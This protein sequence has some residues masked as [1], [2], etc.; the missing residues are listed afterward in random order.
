MIFHYLLF[1]HL[2]LAFSLFILFSP[3]LFSL[4]LHTSYSSFKPS[5]WHQNQDFLDFSWHSSFPAPTVLT[6]PGRLGLAIDIKP[7]KTLYTWISIW[8]CRAH[9]DWRRIFGSSISASSSFTCCYCCCRLC[10]SFGTFGE[11]K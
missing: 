10:T 11:V 5:E 9:H 7:T 8:Y 1:S 6:E 4:F 2:T 3:P